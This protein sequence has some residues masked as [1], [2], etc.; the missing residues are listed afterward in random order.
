[1]IDTILHSDASTSPYVVFRP[2]LL[3]ADAE[4]AVLEIARERFNEAVS[5]ESLA[6]RE[7][8]KCLTLVMVTE[9]SDITGKS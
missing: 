9:T 6:F 4:A 8:Y 5:S 1:M 7:A 3:L 2:I